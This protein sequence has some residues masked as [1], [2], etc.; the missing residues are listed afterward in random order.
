MATIITIEGTDIVKDS[1]SDINTNFTNL[2]A[3]K[4][5]ADDLLPYLTEAEADI[6]Y[7]PKPSITKFVFDGSAQAYALAYTFNPAFNYRLRFENMRFPL[8][9]L[10]NRTIELGFSQD[11]GASHAGTYRFHNRVY[12]SSTNTVSSDRATGTNNFIIRAGTNLNFSS[13]VTMNGILDV[14]GLNTPLISVFGNWTW[15][16]SSTT[17]P[18]FIGHDFHAGVDGISD[19]NG[20]RL[21]TLGASSDDWF[22][23]TL[24]IEKIAKE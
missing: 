24:Y 4:L 1:R 7:A 17:P 2:N 12:P 6:L 5:E 20:L 22:Q 23:G 18:L 9:A 3:D 8:T 16:D 13:T 19:L 21:R 10:T 15:L 11:A 14:T